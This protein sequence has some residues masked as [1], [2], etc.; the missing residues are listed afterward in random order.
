MEDKITLLLPKFTFATNNLGHT[1]CKEWAGT[2]VKL[3]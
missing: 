1:V 2:D 3:P